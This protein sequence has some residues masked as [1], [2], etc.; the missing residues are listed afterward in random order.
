MSSLNQETKAKINAML[1]PKL[2]EMRARYDNA[3]ASVGTAYTIA[4]KIGTNADAV[5]SIARF[6]TK[7]IEADLNST[8]EILDAKPSEAISSSI[9]KPS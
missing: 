3:R 5:V 4:G 8:L 2:A 1:D 7:A 9:P 6:L